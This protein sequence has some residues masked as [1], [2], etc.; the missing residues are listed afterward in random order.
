MFFIFPITPRGWHGR[1]FPFAKVTK[2]IEVEV[3]IPLGIIPWGHTPLV[4]KLVIYSKIGYRARVPWISGAQR[5]WNHSFKKTKEKEL[6]IQHIST[7][8][9][10]LVLQ[11]GKV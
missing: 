6:I 11:F 7:S 10:E 8:V 3:P 4:E 9:P 2:C 5:A 1:E